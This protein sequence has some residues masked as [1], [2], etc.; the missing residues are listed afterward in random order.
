MMAILTGVRWNL[1]VPPPLSQ[2]FQLMITGQCC[3]S[4]QLP[5]LFTFHMGSGSSLL[6]CGFFLP[7]PLSQT[8]LLLVAGHA[9]LLPPEPLRPTRLAYLQFQEGFPSPN[10]QC[11]VCPTLFPTCLYCSYCLLFSFSF[12]PRWRS[13]CPRGYAAV[14]QGC[15]WE[16]HSTAKLTLSVSS[17]AVWAQAIGS[18]A[19]LFVV[20]VVL[21]GGTL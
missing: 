7:L 11:S 14:A 10:L 13:V 2:A 6:S 9:P 1:S 18:Q 15:L 4:C 21:S 12:L 3:C 20:V 5:C 16:Y 19:F 17:Q 8:L